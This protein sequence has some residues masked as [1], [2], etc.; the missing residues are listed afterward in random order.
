[1]ET[2][3]PLPTL[4]DEPHISKAGKYFLNNHSGNENRCCSLLRVI[5]SVAGHF[6]TTTKD[7]MLCFA[8]QNFGDSY[9]VSG[10]PP[11]A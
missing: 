8:T 4:S 10:V 6:Y 2:K 11:C 9:F 1:M 3:E 5:G 7:K